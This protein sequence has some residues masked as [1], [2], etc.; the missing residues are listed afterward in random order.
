MNDN[1]IARRAVTTLPCPG[2]AFTACA[3]TRAA[4]ANPTFRVLDT[5][6]GKQLAVQMRLL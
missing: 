5:E 4:M 3:Q 1:P 2:L 6:R